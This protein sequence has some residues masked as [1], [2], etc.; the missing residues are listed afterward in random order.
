M[1]IHISRDNSPR[2]RNQAV[3]SV[4]KAF[5]WTSRDDA[6]SL[7]IVVEHFYRS[8]WRNATLYRCVV[9]CIQLDR[10]QVHPR[11]TSTQSNRFLQMVHF[12]ICSIK[13]TSRECFTLLLQLCYRVGVSSGALSICR[14]QLFKTRLLKLLI[15]VMW[16]LRS[17]ST[18]FIFSCRMS[19]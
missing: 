14:Q 4:M 3:R 18:A 15:S 17:T 2:S 6:L 11:N 5:L 16:V 9:R 10:I 8:L 13:I 19:R 12:S 7:R 1:L